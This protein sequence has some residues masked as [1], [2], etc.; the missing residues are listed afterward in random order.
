MQEL[1]Y[2][3]NRVLTDFKN[4]FCVISLYNHFQSRAIAMINDF[5]IPHFFAKSLDSLKCGERTYR[6][7]QD[8]RMLKYDNNC[9]IQIFFILGWNPFIFFVSINSD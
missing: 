9:D 5:L 6:Q 3:N 2:H 8:T 1:S 7:S 4:I